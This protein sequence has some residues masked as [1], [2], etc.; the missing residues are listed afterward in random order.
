MPSRTELKAF[1]RILKKAYP[2]CRMRWS[3]ARECYRLERR[4][5]YGRAD[6]DPASIPR[7]AV[8]TLIMRREGFYLVRE[9]GTL[10]NADRL[11]QA[12]YA[13]DTARMDMGTDDPVEAAARYAQRIEDAEKERVAKGRRDN[14]FEHSGVGSDLYNQLAWAEGRRIAVPTNATGVGE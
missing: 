1:N 8:D 5:N 3:D 10:P 9:F 4:A 7:S 6:I 2:D 13:G 14:S 11:V 12:L